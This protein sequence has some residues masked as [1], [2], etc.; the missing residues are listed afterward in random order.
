MLRNIY[1]ENSEKELLK[2][3]KTGEYEI[4][5]IKTSPFQYLDSN[6]KVQVV[7]IIHNDQ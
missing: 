3:T 2:P 7:G 1:S 4:D 6:S 5:G